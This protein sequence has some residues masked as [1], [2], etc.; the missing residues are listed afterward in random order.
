MPNWL[1]FGLLAIAFTFMLA[2]TQTGYWWWVA[3]QEK[4]QEDLLRRISGGKTDDGQGP[5]SI[6]REQRSDAAANALGSLGARI[7]QA[8]LSSDSTTTVTQ[9]VVQMAVSSAVAALVGFFAIGPIG[10]GL[11]IPGAYAPYFLLN[12]RAEKRTMRLVE[13]LPDALDLMSRAIQ[14]GVGLSDA[15]RLAAEEMEPPVAIEFARVFE[16]IR[17]GRDFRE[18]FQGMIARNPRVFDLRLMVSS[19]LLQ[20]E[21]GGNLI[22]ILDNI[23]ETIRGRFTF[24]QKVRAMTSEA[25]FTAIILGSLPIFVT[26]ILLVMSPEYLMILFTDL[27]GNVILAG[28]GIM[29]GTGTV[30]M[31]DLSKV[32]V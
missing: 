17:F 4:Q 25:K 7:Q 15:F 11:S 22:E 16:E 18:A 30:I 24:Q 6:M 14:A 1:L 32:E 3:R 10:L 12:R 26:V 20:R 29:Y 31:R 5:E 27:R 23:S 19:I 21:T 8:L 13:Q 28:C 2:A 9:I